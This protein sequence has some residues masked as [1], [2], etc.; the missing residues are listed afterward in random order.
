MA[1][2]VDEMLSQYGES[3]RRSSDLPSPVERGVARPPGAIGGAGAAGILDS[4]YGNTDA[5]D[6]EQ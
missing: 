2:D 3:P 5:V 4:Y 6:R 1:D